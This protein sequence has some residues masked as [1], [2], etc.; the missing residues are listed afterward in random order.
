MDWHRVISV[1]QQTPDNDFCHFSISNVRFAF[2]AFFRNRKNSGLTPGQ[3]DDP[4]TRTWKM[5]QM[6]NWPG[7]PMTQFHVW[8][9]GG[10]I[11]WQAA[12]NS[13]HGQS[14]MYV[15]SQSVSQR[16][17]QT[18]RQWLE[19]AAADVFA[20]SPTERHF[21]DA[22]RRRSE[23]TLTVRQQSAA[24]T[25]HRRGRCGGRPRPPGSET[26]GDRL[27]LRGVRGRARSRRRRPCECRSVASVD[28]W[29]SVVH[30]TVRRLVAFHSRG[31]YEELG[32]CSAIHR[33]R[34]SYYV[35]LLATGSVSRSAKNENR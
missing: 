5:T 31:M 13:Y 14:D 19:N 10:P 26:A 4:V 27:R 8:W 6:T 9:A 12:H 11:H 21:C 3:N 30:L 33:Q 7:D 2:W 20:I 15:R 29:T 24:R 18:D 25:C 22:C 32:I 28:D 1:Q 34:D 16:D 23:L 35:Q 17:R